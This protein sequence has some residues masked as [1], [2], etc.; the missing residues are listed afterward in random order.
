MVKITTE[1]IYNI[2]NDEWQDEDKI[3]ENLKEKLGVNKFNWFRKS[4]YMFFSGITTLKLHS[5][6]ENLENEKLIEHKIEYEFA[7]NIHYYRRLPVIKR[8]ILYKSKIKLGIE[9]YVA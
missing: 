8:A 5:K 2:I 9:D 7:S 3:R 4:L 1:D 6:L